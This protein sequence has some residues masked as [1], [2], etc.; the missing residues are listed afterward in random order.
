M[1]KSKLNLDKKKI[2]I[3]GAAGGIGE[4]ISQ[5]F[6]ENGAELYLHYHTSQSKAEAL[7]SLLGAHVQLVQ[8]DLSN[9]AQVEKMFS[10]LP[11]LDHVIAN[12][13]F[14]ESASA[15]I[16]DMSLD[17]WKKTMDNNLT[18]TFLTAKYFFQNIEKFQTKA[19]SL[20]M[21]GSTAGHF[22]EK[23]HADYASAKAAIMSGLLPTLKNEITRIAPL[24]RVNVVAP[25]WT[26]TPMAEEFLEDKQAVKKTMQTYAMTK[27][28]KPEDVAGAVLF[29]C[30]SLAN[31]ISGEILK[32]TGGME[33]RV[34][35]EKDEI[36]L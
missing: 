15:P 28:A 30:S 3:T 20:V 36:S 1:T 6:H 22:G 5:Y 16:K 29:L 35:W 4:L 31:H 33:G 14:Y 21:I 26:V 11:A 25:G 8:A 27:L 17:Q 2:L 24:G 12:A 19:P 10:K 34:L 9:E 13:G 18:S 32:V 23:G 7:K